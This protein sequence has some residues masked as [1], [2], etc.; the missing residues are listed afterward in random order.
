MQKLAEHQANA[1]DKQRLLSQQQ[2][3]KILQLKLEHEA[4]V[5]SQLREAAASHGEAVAAILAKHRSQMNNVSGQLL[6]HKE[7]S[8]AKLA[9][10]SAQLF[11]VKQQAS[12]MEQRHDELQQQHSVLLAAHDATVQ[13]SESLQRSHKA[14][15]AQLLIENR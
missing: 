7:S 14:H 10:S 12:E 4:S 11:S 1:D 8:E 13:S 6:L 5:A 3:D 9:A 15:L 2:A